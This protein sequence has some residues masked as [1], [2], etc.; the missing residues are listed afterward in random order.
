VPELCASPSR[1]FSS[2]ISGANCTGTLYLVNN[3]AIASEICFCPCS[4]PV[5]LRG[6]GCCGFRGLSPCQRRCY[7]VGGLLLSVFTACRFT[8]LWLLWVPGAFT[9]STTLPSRRRFA[10]IRVHRFRLRSSTS[11]FSLVFT[12]II[13]CV[14]T[15][16]VQERQH[17]GLL[18]RQ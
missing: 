5:G 11:R 1:S 17:Y 2:D 12:L 15:C 3:T 16:L 10:I 18:P 4:P 6:S 14:Q 8:W 13:R 7:L 9:S